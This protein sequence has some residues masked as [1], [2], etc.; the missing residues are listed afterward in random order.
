MDTEKS[1]SQLVY[2]FINTTL[3]D[4]ESVGIIK[5]HT[6]SEYNKIL[7]K[8][9]KYIGDSNK[10]G[11]LQNHTWQSNK[12]SE[13]ARALHSNL[14]LHDIADNSV[15]DLH[16][17]KVMA[18]V[19]HFLS[20][21]VI[22]ALVYNESIFLKINSTLGK[23]HQRDYTSIDNYK[24]LPVERKFATI[25]K[26]VRN[27]YKEGFDSRIKFIRKL[28]FSIDEKLIDS[29]NFCYRVRNDIVH[30]QSFVSKDNYDFYKDLLKKHKTKNKNSIEPG[31]EGSPDLSGV[32]I[33]YFEKHLK[34]IIHCHQKNKKMV[35]DKNFFGFVYAKAIEMGIDIGIKICDNIDYWKIEDGNLVKKEDSF[36]FGLTQQLQVDL[37]L[38]FFNKNT[39]S[40]NKNDF[41][42][43]GVLSIVQ[44]SIKTLE[45]LTIKDWTGENM[46]FD[47]KSFTETK[48]NLDREK[49][50]F[51]LVN[52]LA[53]YAI[54]NRMLDEYQKIKKREIDLWKNVEKDRKFLMQYPQAK[55][56]LA[57]F[58]KDGGFKYKAYKEGNLRLLR[59]FKSIEYDKNSNSWEELRYEFGLNL[60]LGEYYNA[61]DVLYRVKKF[62]NID[63]SNNDCDTT[64]DNQA[65]KKIILHML[66][67]P[68]AL[69][70]RNNKDLKKYFKVTFD[71]NITQQII[72]KEDKN[73]DDDY[74]KI[75]Q[76]T[77]ET[78][79]A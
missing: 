16:I 2:D 11:L 74:A 60:I 6:E 13:K 65:W 56:Q 15:Y 47:G 7:N 45:S 28:G 4:M 48:D 71:E 41:N 27:I 62:T 33:V 17:I 63:D 25:K 38:P 20:E 46:Y 50:N 68:I 52:L 67:W 31:S 57:D 21:I 76:Q 9:N 12:A 39:Y 8:Y 37:L 30:N 34:D 43:M 18:L 32:V 42:L 69:K 70:Y 19:E 75:I 5:S 73:F 55:A 1:V 59:H 72:D 23:Q 79:I 58:K 78:V 54:K 77:D 44:S 40:D 36:L 24:T 49:K 22:Y 61:T 64:K 3:N 14:N 66:G 10:S 35:I 51:L 53:L 29:Y 26:L